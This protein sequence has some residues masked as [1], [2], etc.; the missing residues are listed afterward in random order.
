MGERHGIR[1]D[2]TI[3]VA[4]AIVLI[5]AS[6]LFFGVRSGYWLTVERLDVQD[7][8]VGDSDIII[9]YQRTIH[10]RFAADWNVSIDREGPDGLDWVCTSPVQHD[11][12]EVKA[13]L[14]EPVTLE[15]FAW[16]DKRC[17]DLAPGT[18]HITAHWEI[19]PESLFLK[20]SV[21]ATDV[22]TVL[23]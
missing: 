13:K 5:V 22:F 1:I 12:Y 23:P 8:R 4:V 2:E 10:R 19:N 3:G 14:P 11:V 9:D 18:Y 16:S 6:A 15:W 20:R 21:S 17:Y 7:S